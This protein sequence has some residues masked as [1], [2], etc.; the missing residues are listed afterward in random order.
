MER[1]FEFKLVMGLICL[2][3]AITVL[4]VAYFIDKSDK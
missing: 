2:F 1:Y 3:S 4:G